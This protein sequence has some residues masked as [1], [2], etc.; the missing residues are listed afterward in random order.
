[1][2]DFIIDFDQRRVALKAK[3]ASERR[4]TRR[5]L[6]S[7]QTKAVTIDHHRVSLPQTSR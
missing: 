2:N 3:R 6:L 5:F 7:G 1:V 4:E